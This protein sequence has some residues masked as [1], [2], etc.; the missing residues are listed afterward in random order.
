VISPRKNLW[1]CLGACQAGGS[2]VDWV[3]RSE[4]VSFRHAVE[5]LR[6]DLPLAAS[7]ASGPPPKAFSVKRLP[8]PVAGDVADDE[9]LAQVVTYYH[10]TL[11]ASPEALTYLQ[12][13]GLR[14]MELV[15]RL[16]LGFANRTLGHRLP[17][18][19][20]RAGAELRSR[21]QRLGILRE[22]G[23]EHFNGSIVIPVVDANGRVT[24]MY[25]R[26]VGTKTAYGAVELPVGPDEHWSDMGSVTGKSEQ[27]DRWM[28]GLPRGGQRRRQK[29]QPDARARRAGTSSSPQSD[30][31]RLERDARNRRV[32]GDHRIPGHRWRWSRD[33]LAPRRSHG[34][35]RCGATL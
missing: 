32:C 27:A 18:K 21:L 12:T 16:Q 10:E 25:G 1:H 17:D 35:A 15:E 31:P 4:G 28:A 24:E 29:G 30:L 11:K 13:R 8:A 3:M 20:R 6:A 2:V 26:K 5:L 34:T 7:S 14:S 33:R 9:A 23:H 22:S 19:N